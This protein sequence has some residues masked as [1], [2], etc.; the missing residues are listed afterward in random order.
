MGVLMETTRFDARPGEAMTITLTASN[1]GRMTDTYTATL[2]GLPAAWITSPTP[3][4][5]VGPGEKAELAFTVVTPAGLPRR[6]ENARSPSACPA[7][8]RP[9]KPPPSSAGSTYRKCMSSASRCCRTRPRRAGRRDQDTEP[10]QRAH[11]LHPDVGNPRRER[12][13]SSRPVRRRSPSAPGR[14]IALRICHACDADRYLAAPPTTPTALWWLL[15]KSDTSPGPKWSAKGLA[16]SWLGTV[17]V[18][19]VVLTLLFYLVVQWA[20]SQPPILTPTPDL[21]LT[22]AATPT[23]PPG[24]TPVG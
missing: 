8:N 1:H 18:F 2:E 10:G 4:A 11:H 23:V 19:A 20:V 17:A 12:F 5:L 7:A 3:T 9:T 16:P 14:P 13:T 22:P 21:T 15:P 24:L 6:P